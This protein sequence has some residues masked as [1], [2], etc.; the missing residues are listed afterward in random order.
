MRFS[1]AYSV[2]DFQATVDAFESGAVEPRALVDREIG[3][4]EVPAHLENMRAGKVSGNKVHVDP[5]RNK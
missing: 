4:D 2:A 1:A 3:L 5:S